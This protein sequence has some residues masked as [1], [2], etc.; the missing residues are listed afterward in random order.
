MA[1]NFDVVKFQNMLLVKHELVVGSV[2]KLKELNSDFSEYVRF[3]NTLIDLINEE[4]VYFLLDPSIMDKLLE[5]LNE[6]RFSSEYTKIRGVI[7]DIIGAINRIKNVDEAE[8]QM[9]LANY[10]AYQEKSRG[11]KIDTYHDLLYVVSSDAIAFENIIGNIDIIEDDIMFVVS[12]KYFVNCAP[13]IFLNEQIYKNTV[14]IL[15]R[16]SKMI[17]PLDIK[18]KVHMKKLLNNIDQL[19]KKEE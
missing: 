4:N 1:N 12:I 16:F 18:S 9:L 11:V 14:T 15:K 2:E 7:S 13:E 5:F 10:K 8:K 3:I 19:S 17:R 6:D